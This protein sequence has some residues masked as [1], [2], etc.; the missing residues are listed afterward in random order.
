MMSDIAAST[1]LPADKLFM[2]TKI[3]SILLVDKSSMK[4]KPRQF[5]DVAM[6]DIGRDFLIAGRGRGAY[7]ARRLVNHLD[8]PY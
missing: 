3:M 8:S 7:I 5:G 1:S 2:E 4:T 6:A